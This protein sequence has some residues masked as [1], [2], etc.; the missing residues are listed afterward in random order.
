MT[1][2]AATIMGG[3]I[4]PDRRSAA[5]TSRLI[6]IAQAIE[7]IAAE[8]LNGTQGTIDGEIASTVDTPR[9]E[10]KVD[11]KLPPHTDPSGEFAPFPLFT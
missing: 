3:D 7:T 11:S 1:A 9:R 4:W 8:S 10:Q 2:Q 5:I 6:R